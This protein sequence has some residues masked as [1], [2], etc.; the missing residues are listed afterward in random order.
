MSTPITAAGAK[1]DIFF[2]YST[3]EPTNVLLCTLVWLVFDK[4]YRVSFTPSALVSGT[5]Q[6]DEI[7]K[8][9][10][11]CSL[12]VVCLDGLRPNVIHEWGYMRGLNRPVILLKKEGATVDLRH[13]TREAAPQLENPPLDMNSHLSNL[14]D[15]NYA[16]WYP[17]DPPRS[18]KAI[19]DEY[20]KIR[21]K[22][23]K[24]IEVEEPRLW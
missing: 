24:L 14:K 9:I 23:T 18:V 10:V 5:S 1:T 15:I 17:E 4:Q 11:N 16:K 20:N 22:F 21:V 8:Q 13:F 6:L 19:W 2:S 7:E 12:A 3:A